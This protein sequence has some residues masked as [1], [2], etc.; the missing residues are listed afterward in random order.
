[1][2]GI[3][4]ARVAWSQVAPLPSY[5][6]QWLCLASI[7]CSVQARATEVST[8]E[9]NCAAMRLVPLV[10]RYCSKS[11]VLANRVSARRL[12]NVISGLWFVF[13]PPL[14]WTLKLGGLPRLTAYCAAGVHGA[15][16]S[17]AGH[18]RVLRGLGALAGGLALGR[19]RG[20]HRG[21]RDSHLR[22][23]RYVSQSA[24]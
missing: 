11:C 6:A 2:A 3:H 4:A 8:A 19:G 21:R 5:S 24:G 1:M 9:F 22:R 15:G 23:Y 12:D 20:F 7:F 13:W 14:S 16:V 10:Y 17:R 18:D